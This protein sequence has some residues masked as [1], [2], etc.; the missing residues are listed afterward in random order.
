MI[1]VIW[2]LGDIHVQK[3]RTPTRRLLIRR[4]ASLLHGYAIIFPQSL[5]PYYRWKVE[6]RPEQAVLSIISIRPVSRKHG[7]TV[8]AQST[9]RTSRRSNAT[10]VRGGIKT[11]LPPSNQPLIQLPLSHHGHLVQ[12]KKG[13]YSL[14][15]IMMILITAFR[16]CRLKSKKKQLWRQRS[17]R[18]EPKE[19]Y[20]IS[21]SAA[22]R[23]YSRCASS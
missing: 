3:S 18:W 10:K 4:Y 5:Y 20:H 15:N 19:T 2:H 16:I 12:G 21:T 6:A 11:Q 7:N 1:L 14:M 13:M 17:N 9:P 23:I 8:P 22:P